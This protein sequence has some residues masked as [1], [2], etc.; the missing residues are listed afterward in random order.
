MALIN[1][2]ECNASISDQALQCPQ[3]GYVQN[4]Q[5]SAPLAAEP[6]PASPGAASDDDL[7]DAAIG[8]VNKSY[9]RPKFDRFAALQ[10]SVSWNWPAFFVTIFWMLYRRMY[11]YA[12]LVW[13]VLPVVLIVVA[14]LVGGISGDASASISTYYLLHAIIGFIVIPMFA[15]RLYYRHATRKIARSF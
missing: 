10:G 11:A 15:N 3:C 12:V 4:T 8:P 2:P 14:G 7:L 6:A 9:Y 1:C 5:A 13:F